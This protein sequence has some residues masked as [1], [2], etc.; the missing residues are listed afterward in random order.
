MEVLLRIRNTLT[1]RMLQRDLEQRVL[2]RTQ[3]LEDSRLEVLQRLAAV[4]E[5]RDTSTEE[6]NRRVGRIAHAIA[7]SVPAWEGHAELVGLAARLHDV[8]KVGI[9]DATLL[10]P[11][12]LDADERAAMQRHASIGSRI[13]GGSRSPLLRMAAVIAAGHHERWDGAGYPGN[14]AEE[15]IPW[16]ARVTAVA[17]V[18]DALTHDR[19]Y[20]PAWS[21]EDAREEIRRG[22]G[23][24]FDPTAVEA[25]LGLDPRALRN[26]NGAR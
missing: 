15:D 3:E 12:P 1:L 24:H 4:A 16:E 6:H 13:L 2:E 25:F 14:I 10:K 22:A 26:G 23:S 18:F 20:K 8:G 17:D 7:A 9:P 11:G 21:V 19:P 5:Y